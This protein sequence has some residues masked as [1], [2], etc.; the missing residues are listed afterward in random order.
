MT[1]RTKPY[2][3]PRRQQTPAQE[4]ANRRSFL[5]FR[6]RGLWELAAIVSP[7]RRE[8]IRAIVDAD[9]VDLGAIPHREKHEANRAA[10]QAQLDARRHDQN[11]ELPF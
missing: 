5:I 7:H 8:Q 9:L 1:L 6:L 11:E 2:S 4:A 3:A 10:F